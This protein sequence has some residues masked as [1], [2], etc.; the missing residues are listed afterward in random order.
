MRKLFCLLLMPCL[1]FGFISC[2]DDDNDKEIYDLTFERGDYTVMEESG[3]SIMVRSGN[4]DYT[5][6]SEDSLIATASY[7]EANVGFGD[8]FITPKK[9]GQTV[10]RVKDNVVNQEVKLN[11]TVTNKYLSLNVYETTAVVDIDDT[12]QKEEIEK[13]LAEVTAFKKY[14]SI[15]LIDDEVK[16]SYVFKNVEDIATGNYLY[17]GTYEFRMIGN[18]PYLDVSYMNGEVETI[19]PYVL[20]GDEAIAGISRYFDLGWVDSTLR[21]YLPSPVITISLTQNSAG[22]YISKY[23]ALRDANWVMQANL[24]LRTYL[25]DE[26][27]K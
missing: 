19:Q 22:R 8:I 6:T 18:E 9:K 11:I 17:K 15:F 12:K 20:S 25:P 3:Y 4:G 26:L 7:S 2:S 16:T 24:S 27:L 10:I 23:P 5:I 13:D 21:S 14:F 1:L